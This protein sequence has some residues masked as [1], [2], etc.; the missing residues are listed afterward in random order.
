MPTASNHPQRRRPRQPPRQSVPGHSTSY[1]TAFY[2]SPCR[3]ESLAARASERTTPT[4]IPTATTAGPRT[5]PN[6]GPIPPRAGRARASSRLPTPCFL[7]WRHHRRRRPL[8]AAAA[9]ASGAFSEL[10]R[11]RYRYRHW[12]IGHRRRTPRRQRRR[13]QE[14]GMLSQ[15]SRIRRRPEQLARR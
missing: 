13:P 7:S 14:Q 3:P 1:R 4:A 2:C 6:L 15:G 11:Y 8:L 12:R 9:A 10:R 5:T